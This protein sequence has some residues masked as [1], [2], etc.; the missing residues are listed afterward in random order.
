MDPKAEGKKIVLPVSYGK[1]HSEA[2]PTWS[3]KGHSSKHDLIYKE[4]LLYQYPKKPVLIVEGEKTTDAAQKMLGKE[5]V[6]VSWMGGA[7]AAKDTNWSKLFGRDV[8]IWPD[9]DAAGFKAAAVIGQCL[10]KVGVNSLK[11]VNQDNLKDLP[12]KWDLADPLPENKSP[13][14]IKDTL[15]RAESKAIGIDRIEAMAKQHGLTFKHLNEI[16][17]GVDE[18]IRADL[19]KQHGSKTWEIEAAIITEATKQLPIMGV[20]Q[21]HYRSRLMI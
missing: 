16:V 3:L 10:R 13:S 4:P 6:V 1:N 9:N 15:L 17:S 2:E 21:A 11:I 8:I 18:R 19:E 12:Q 14:F 7:A 20:S 5:Y